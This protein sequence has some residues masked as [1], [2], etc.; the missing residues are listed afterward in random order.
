MKKVKK[1]RERD[2]VNF[3]TSKFVFGRCASKNS[4]LSQFMSIAVVG[5]R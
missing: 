3:F 2:L 4:S 5:A 1:K